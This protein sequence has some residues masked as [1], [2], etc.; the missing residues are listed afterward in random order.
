MSCSI[1]LA[2][3]NAAAAT[4][5]QARLTRCGQGSQ[6]M[7]RTINASD[8]SNS[9]LLDG[10]QRILAA[11]RATGSALVDQ[12]MTAHGGSVTVYYHHKGTR[13]DR[14]NVNVMHAMSVPATRSHLAI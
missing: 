5:L 2:R 8:N 7:K 12:S 11:R 13:V 1:G 3:S 10:L 9:V 4:P 14:L 6:A